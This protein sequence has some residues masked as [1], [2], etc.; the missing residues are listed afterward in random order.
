MTISVDVVDVVAAARDDPQTYVRLEAELCNTDGTVP[1]HKRFRA[2][3][4]LKSLADARAIDIIDK[5]WYSL[6]DCMI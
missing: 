3:F 6:D 1:L 5:G 4:T 2:L